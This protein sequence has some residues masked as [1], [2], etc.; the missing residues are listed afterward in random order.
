MFKT[1]RVLLPLL[2]APALLAFTPR[3]AE[4]AY[5]PAKDLTLKK[6]ITSTSEM[7]M[8]EMNLVVDGQEMDQGGDMEMEMSQSQTLVIIDNYAEVGTDQPIKLSRTFETISDDSTRAMSHPMMG[9]NETEASGESELEGKT[10]VFQWDA[11]DGD[12]VVKYAEGSEADE[13]LLAGLVEDVDLRAFL[14]D[15]EV[16]E[17]ASWNV[18]AEAMRVVLAPGGNLH[19]SQDTSGEDMFGSGPEPSMAEMLGDLEG[20]VTCT[21]EGMRDEGGTPVAAIKLAIEVT[22]TNDLAEF[23][24]EQ[25]ANQEKPE[26]MDIEM[27][28][29]SMDIEFQ[30]EAEGS[31][32]W[33]VEKGIAHSMT[34]E[35]DIGLTTDTAMAMAFM[36]QE[37]TIEQ[38][39]IMAGSTQMSM[40]F[41]VQ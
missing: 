9:D 34:L 27:D 7:A 18:E 38:S 2:V 26:G 8:D 12:Y 40:A 28:I 19:I 20:K 35:G 4:I 29:E 37:Q 11:E 22:S 1:R 24:A 39:M 30:F 10:V 15:G 14:P 3:G 16:A 31:L 41:E 25:I 6:T 23:L 33:N 5:S 17:G 13:E 21:L 32:L 36:G